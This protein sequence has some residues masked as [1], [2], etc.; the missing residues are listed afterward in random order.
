MATDH[1]RVLILQVTLKSVFAGEI[2]RIKLD[3]RSEFCRQNRLQSLAEPNLPIDFNRLLEEGRGLGGVIDV[4][5]PRPQSLSQ[6]T[7]ETL[8]GRNPIDGI[9][10][11]MREQKVALVFRIF[12]V[13]NRL[14]R[15]DRTIEGR[16]KIQFER[17][18]PVRLLGEIPEQN[19]G[20]GQ[21]GTRRDRSIGAEDVTPGESIHDSSEGVVVEYLHL[22]SAGI[23]PAGDIE[24]GRSLMQRDEV[25]PRRAV[26]GHAMAGIEQQLFRIELMA[27][28]D[29][30]HEGSRDILDSGQRRPERVVP[31]PIRIAVGD[32]AR[33]PR[34]FDRPFQT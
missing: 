33:P 6:I 22:V 4:R 28:T 17:A 27:G 10:D 2:D 16:S 7:D 23:D 21:R 31:I 13:Q 9:E 34:P 25:I 30:V 3:R 29:V 24:R 11:A 8:F 26:G 20:V 19:L 1:R 18:I 15:R 32:T 12:R 5:L 14:V